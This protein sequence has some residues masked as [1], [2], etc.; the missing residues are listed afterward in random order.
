MVCHKNDKQ[1][2]GRR[3]I[4]ITNINLL[5]VNKLERKIYIPNKIFG[6]T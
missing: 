3:N 2:G 5:S 1:W 6:T 4:M